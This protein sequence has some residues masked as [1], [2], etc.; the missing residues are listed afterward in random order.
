MYYN[1]TKIFVYNAT[2]N[3]CALAL[4]KNQNHYCLVCHPKV[5]ATFSEIEKLKRYETF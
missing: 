5:F 4:N 3:K 1:H 2:I